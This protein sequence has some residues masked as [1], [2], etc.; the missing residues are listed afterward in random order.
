M[1][2]FPI[3]H[4]LRTENRTWTISSV[5][6]IQEPLHQYPYIRFDQKEGHAT[7]FEDEKSYYGISCIP[8]GSRQEMC[9]DD[10]LI[11]PTKAE[12]RQRKQD[13]QDRKRLLV[14]M[15]PPDQ[16]KTNYNYGQTHQLEI[17]TDPD[18]LNYSKSYRLAVALSRTFHYQTKDLFNTGRYLLF[19]K[20]EF[21]QEQ[22]IEGLVISPEQ[23]FPFLITDRGHSGTVLL[24]PRLT[25]IWFLH[26]ET[27][28][29]ILYP[30]N[31]IM[32]QYGFDEVI[33]YAHQ[34]YTPN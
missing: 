8:E 25:P 26:Y 1:L 2:T 27:G 4:H 24:G 31:K 18:L 14:L 13:A 6:F 22:N 21:H 34:I 33:V 15:F 23:Q 30:S 28:E 20:V 17:K 5:T 7:L 3:G 12:A 19:H 29:Y 9:V 10:G 16:P 11:T 32:H